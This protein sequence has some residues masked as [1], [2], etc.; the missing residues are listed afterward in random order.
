[1]SPLSSSSRPLAVVSPE[2]AEIRPPAEHQLVAVLHHQIAGGGVH[3]H[4]LAGASGG[5]GPYAALGAEN[6]KGAIGKTETSASDDRSHARFPFL[7][8]RRLSGKPKISLGVRA[9]KLEREGFATESLHQAD[10]LSRF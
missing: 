1:L 8:L 9:K 10:M 2:Q 4:P 5:S 6:G 7:G 3:V